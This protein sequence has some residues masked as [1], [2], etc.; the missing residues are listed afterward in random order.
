[1]D[2]DKISNCIYYDPKAFT[3]RCL[4]CAEGYYVDKNRN[5]CSLRTYSK[6]IEKCDILNTSSEECEKCVE[7]Y[8]LTDDNLRCLP[9]REN[10]SQYFSSTLFSKELECRECVDGFYNNQK[11]G[12]CTQGSVANC[13]TYKTY[14]D[15][16]K[17]CQN[18][19]Y[20][21]REKK[22]V[23]HTLKDQFQ[24]A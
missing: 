16:C 7:G 1:M 24:C 17:K 11:V 14:T 3:T 15:E 19:Y 20:L 5:K 6:D 13:Q 23:P 9:V 4:L 18:G 21:S 2:V 10:C 8:A 22:C 12:S